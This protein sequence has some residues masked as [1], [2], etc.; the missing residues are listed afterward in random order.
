MVIVPLRN[1]TLILAG[2]LTLLQC[3]KKLKETEDG[4]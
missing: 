3:I 1:K 2:T 4:E